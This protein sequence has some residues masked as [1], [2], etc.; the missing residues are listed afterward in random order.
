M[1]GPEAMDEDQQHL[2]LARFKRLYIL[3]GRLVRGEAHYAGL[4][5]R[6]FR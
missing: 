6:A 2:E 3:Q 4:H 1:S 5:P